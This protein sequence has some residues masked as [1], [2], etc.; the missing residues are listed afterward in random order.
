MILKI[1]AIRD[2]KTASYANPMFEVTDGGMIRNLSDAVNSNEKGNNLYHHSDD[3]ELFQLGTYDTETGLI[4]GQQPRSII[5][6][7]QLK[8]A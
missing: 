3:F 8:K 5:T 2:I 7:T 1:Y 6:A 4:E